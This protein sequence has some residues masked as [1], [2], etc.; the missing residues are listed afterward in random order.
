[1][2]SVRQYRTEDVPDID[3]LYKQLPYMNE[4]STNNAD[5]DALIRSMS[6]D[7][8]F[9]EFNALKSRII[10]ALAAC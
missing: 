8:S 9:Y 2:L 1:M 5:L 6:D 7:L 3:S 4:N 10:S